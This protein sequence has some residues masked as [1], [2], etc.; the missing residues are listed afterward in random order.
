MSAGDADVAPGD[1]PFATLSVQEHA[2]LANWYAAA[3][4]DAADGGARDRV[5]AAAHAVAAMQALSEQPN[6]D[7]ASLAMV[8][9]ALTLLFGGVEDGDSAHNAELALLNSQHVL[10]L[11]ERLGDDVAVAKARANLGNAYFARR[12]GSKAA[13]VEQAIHEFNEALKTLPEGSGEWV[14]TQANLANAYLDRP[15]GTQDK[16]IDRAIGCVRDALR[17]VTHVGDPERW[18]DLEN[19]LGIALTTAP[20]SDSD[21]REAIAHFESALA[22][23][24]RQRHPLMWADLHSNLSRAL[25]DLHDGNETTNLSAAIEHLDSALEVYTL[26]THPRGHLEIQRALGDK[27]LR[28][29]RLDESHT[30][31]SGAIDATRL[32]FADAFTWSGRQVEVASAAGLFFRDSYCLARLGR[33]DE[34]LSRLEQGRARV[35]NEALSVLVARDADDA[36]GTQIAEAQARV[37]GL[38]REHRALEAYAPVD[39]SVDLAIELA[40]ARQALVGLVEAVRPQSFDEPLHVDALLAAIPTNSVLV[41][42]IVTD[43][44]T[45]VFVVPGNTTALGQE[46]LLFVE[47]FT[48]R[49][50]HELLAG[51][52]GWLPAHNQRNDDR[53]LWLQTITATCTR[54][55]DALIGRVEAHL[56]TLA[57]VPGTPL[58]LVAPGLLGILP[59]HAATRIVDGTERCLAE[60]YVV[61]YT[62]SVA[63][64]ARAVDKVQ[65]ERASPASGLVITVPPKLLRFAEAEG[66]AVSSSFDQNTRQELGGAKV[67]LKRILAGAVTANYLHFACHGRWLPGRPLESTLKFQRSELSLADILAR[68]DLGSTRLAV[69]SACETGLFEI[70]SAADEEF[71]M[72]TGFLQAG[73]ACVVSSLW[74]VDD[75]ATMLLMRSFYAMMLGTESWSPAIALRMAQSWLKTTTNQ[76]FAETLRAMRTTADP[77]HAAA[78]DDQ[79]TR[80]ALASNPNG[81]P[82]EHPYYWAAFAV[83]GA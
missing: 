1:D 61:S 15:I 75:I 4:H 62:P 18:A 22:V 17:T 7:A 54:L 47:Q 2:A 44:G 30:A 26:H 10:S 40:D 77:L 83:H 23:T 11:A 12:A 51:E 39:A 67:T 35:L 78:L 50:V 69:L 56:Q 6:D 32:L 37:R 52:A 70:Q 9:N 59:L 68:L 28:A 57:V 19:M 79:F 43:V 36:A 41:A 74:L 58:Y 34:S 76:G 63:A 13:N 5:V 48:L 46:H 8:H 55:W 27:L 73:A 24:E 81:R 49:D 16:N 38:E 66:A 14:D 21:L 25:A 65:R 29:G 33:L 42:P 60:D 71:G 3:S 45:E 80:F 31:L 20:G 53:R 82:F 72:T 64:L